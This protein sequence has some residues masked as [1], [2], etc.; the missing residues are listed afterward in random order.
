MAGW[1]EKALGREKAEPVQSVPFSVTCQCGF[2][3]DGQ[4]QERAKRVIC[5][6]CGAGHF[7]LPMNRYPTSQRRFFAEDD[8]SFITA[9]QPKPK[10]KPPATEID[11]AEDPK[12][13]DENVDPFIDEDF[14][15][16]E[17]QL[18]LVEAAW[19]TGGNQTT[20][21]DDDLDDDDDG[22]DYE[23]ADSDAEIELP[24]QLPRSNK[25]KKS[26]ASRI[27]NRRKSVVSP[28]SSKS[29]DKKREPQIEVPTASDER[30]G[31]R[32]R[33]A[34]VC[35]LIVV[36]VGTMVAF[37]IRGRTHDQAEIAMREGR[38]IGEVAL[39]KRD[40][41]TARLKLSEAVQ[42]M[43]LLGIDEKTTAE[44]RNLWL[45]A[46]AGFGLLDST[47]VVEI[48]M[49]AEEM[50]PEPDDEGKI[51]DEDWRRQFHTRFFDRWLCIQ[52]ELADVVSG[53]DE[54]GRRVVFPAIPLV[55]L[56]GV[57]AVLDGPPEGGLW[58][59][60]PIKSCQRD[61]MDESVWLI[62]FDSSRVIACDRTQSLV[63]PM[64]SEDEQQVAIAA[65]AAEAPSEESKDNEQREPNDE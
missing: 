30:G 43:E 51:D 58:F 11:L 47:D 13:S 48:A 39:R 56:A 64:L 36:A 41:S 62:E 24:P 27:P 12:S 50:I 55:H 53:D 9:Q 34:G 54:F 22:D 31:Q 18:D 37:A 57:D 17:P 26:S 52:L 35:V 29:G 16:T 45:Q 6:D 8:P 61:P 33:I 38:D 25:K 23:L 3:I 4:R 59:A 40:F 20:H 65:L 46:E 63:L 7:I 60:G 5:A 15:Q 44:T 49:L 10:K 14:Q 19:S 2:Q 21:A 28:A 32:L 42:A 1:L